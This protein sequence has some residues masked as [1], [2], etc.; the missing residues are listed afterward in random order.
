MKT[1]IPKA[2]QSIFNSKY[3]SN[4]ETSKKNASKSVQRRRQYQNKAYKKLDEQSS[5]ILKLFV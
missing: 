1:F 3:K 2:N 4:N 5:I